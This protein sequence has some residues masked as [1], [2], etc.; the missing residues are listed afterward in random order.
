VESVEFRDVGLRY[1]QTDA[2]IGV[3]LKVDRGET[4][5][6]VGDSGGGKTSLVNLILRLF[7]PSSGQ[8]LING[9]DSRELDLRGLRSRIGIVTQRVYIFNDTV[10]ANVAYGSEI[11]VDRVRSALE[12][13]GAW[14]FVNALSGGV[15]SVLDEFGTN[16]SGGQRQRL[17]IARALYK[18]PDILILDEATSALD[19]RTEAAIQESLRD[20]IRDKITFVIAHRLSTVDLA[21]RIFVLSGGRI[22]GVGTK[23]SLLAECAEYRR[24]ALKEAGGSGDGS[25]ARRPSALAGGAD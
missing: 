5:A 16:L 13:A 2:L 21:D 17:A 22:V 19:N 12:R 6:L 14:D 4:V 15:D 11:D 24:L 9:V 20:I 25:T 3:S 8:V 1:H 23:E 18:E 7:D 10:A